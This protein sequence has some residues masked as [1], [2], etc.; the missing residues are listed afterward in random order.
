[1]VAEATGDEV[2][3]LPFP[4]DDPRHPQEAGPQQLPALALGQRAPDCQSALKTD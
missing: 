1:M 2:E 4:L 3:H